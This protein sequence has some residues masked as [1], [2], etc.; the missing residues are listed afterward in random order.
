MTNI[1]ASDFVL[2]KYICH[3]QRV[4]KGGV[5]VLGGLFEGVWEVFLRGGWK[6]FPK[7]WMVI[8]PDPTMAASLLTPSQ[9]LQTRFCFKITPPPFLHCFTLMLHLLFVIIETA[10]FLSL[11]LCLT[12]WKISVLK[13]TAS[14]DVGTL[15]KWWNMFEHWCLHIFLKEI[16]WNFNF[17]FF[18]FVAR[19]AEREKIVVHYSVKRST[20]VS[21]L[22]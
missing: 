9:F 8:E 6:G 20:T 14:R 5:A 4:P 13:T 19:A 16:C 12:I 17:I 2:I 7:W 10:K 1:S 11:K 22:L 3:S 15:W 21:N 18:S